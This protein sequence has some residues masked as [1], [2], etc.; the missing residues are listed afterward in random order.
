MEACLYVTQF[1]LFKA[2][3]PY[4]TQDQFHQETKYRTLK[5]IPQKYI[6]EKLMIDV[7]LFLRSEKDDEHEEDHMNVGK[8]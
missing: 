5:K 1:F 7:Y 3:I 8:Y 4:P 6:E 2:Q